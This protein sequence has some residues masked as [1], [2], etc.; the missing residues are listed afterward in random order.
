MSLAVLWPAWFWAT[1]Y[2]IMV[3]RLMVQTN[4]CST[5]KRA[6]NYGNYGILLIMGN[7]GFISSTVSIG[8]SWAEESLV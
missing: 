5:L 1:D 6:L 2:S 8:V 7:A 3:V 4:P